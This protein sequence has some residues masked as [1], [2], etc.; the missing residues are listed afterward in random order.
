MD[1]INRIKAITE[2]KEICQDIGCSGLDPDLC[3]NKSYMCDIIKK[4]LKDK[5]D[6]RI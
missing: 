3:Q 6:E 5:S 1:D 2:I 4:L